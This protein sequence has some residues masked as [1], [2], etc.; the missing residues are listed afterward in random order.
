[1]TWGVSVELNSSHPGGVTFPGHCSVPAHVA[2]RRKVLCFPE[3]FYFPVC[4][5]FENTSW[6]LKQLSLSIQETSRS[7][8]NTDQAIPWRAMFPSA[9]Q[10]SR[11]GAAETASQEHWSKRQTG[12]T[13]IDSYWISHLCV[14]T[15]VCLQPWG[16]CHGSWP[17]QCTLMSM[18]C[19]LPSP[20]LCG[21]SNLGDRE[22]NILVVWS[23][24]EING[25]SS[26][27]FKNSI[28]ILNI[29]VP[30]SWSGDVR[31]FQRMW[32][33]FQAGS[34]AAAGEPQSTLRHIAPQTPYWAL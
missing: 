29:D 10:R 2:L 3:G 24:L 33:I 19:V 30:L 32:L 34:L 16:C 9:F 11:A 18:G 12:Q 6:M 21:E 8:P 5:Y 28:A 14:V 25:L 26:C 17:A 13:D 22:K 15:S 7:F 20:Y 27:L 1:M 4:Q 23:E 31:N